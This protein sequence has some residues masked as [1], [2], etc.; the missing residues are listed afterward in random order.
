[1]LEI[2]HVTFERKIETCPTLEFPVLVLL[3][4]IPEPNDFSARHSIV[5]SEIVMSSTLE[6][7]DPYP[8]PIPELLVPLALTLEFTMMMD[9]AVENPF[10]QYPLPRPAPPAE[11]VPDTIA[12]TLE[13]NTRILAIVELPLP[14]IWPPPSPEPDEL[15]A[16]IAESVT[17]TSPSVELPAPIELD[18]IPDPD[19]S[20]RIVEFA[21]VMSPIADSPK[22][23]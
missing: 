21:I 18:P 6:P 14:T 4:P 5:D 9:P 22:A 20:L 16:A 15:H 2:T 1:V 13:F 11:L 12:V 3:L 7:S 17:L 10:V 19:D 23:I 8:L